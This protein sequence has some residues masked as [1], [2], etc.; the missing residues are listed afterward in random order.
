MGRIHSDGL[1]DQS[2]KQQLNRPDAER[3]AQRQR[4]RHHERI[5]AYH[6][7]SC[8]F[9]HTGHSKPRALRRR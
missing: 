2:G 5:S 3:L 8:G 4:R 6:C 7:L 9:W 1:C